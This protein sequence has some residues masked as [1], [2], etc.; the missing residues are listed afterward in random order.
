MRGALLFAGLFFFNAAIAWDFAFS[1]LD[2]EVVLQFCFLLHLLGLAGM[3][4]SKNGQQ[5]SVARCFSPRTSATKMDG[6]PTGAED[7]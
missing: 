1:R 2:H 5:N 7:I 6:S 4:K 3:L